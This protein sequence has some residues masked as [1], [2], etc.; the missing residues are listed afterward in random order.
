M[1]KPIPGER[2]PH[3]RFY[4]VEADEAVIARL[5]CILSPGVVTDIWP[6]LK[7]ALSAYRSDIEE[8]RLPSAHTVNEKRMKIRSVLCELRDMK[9]DIDECGRRFE[10]DD[11]LAATTPCTPGFHCDLFEEIQRL[12]DLGVRQIDEFLR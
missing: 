1:G 5:K 2:V 6:A 11:W 8:L 4:E 10:S 3:F 12:A 9:W 7:L